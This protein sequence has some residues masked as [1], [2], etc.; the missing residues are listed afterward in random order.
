[1]MND[2]QKKFEDWKVEREVD[3]HNESYQ[4]REGY[5]KAIRDAINL[6]KNLVIPRVINCTVEDLNIGDTVLIEH[7]HRFKDDYWDAWS[8]TNYKYLSCAGGV[9]EFEN[10]NYP[11][12][13]FTLMGDEPM[14]RFVGRYCL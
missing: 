4:Y 7:A 2:I 3:Q 1:M 10:I 13:H 14:H 6:V 8:K 12:E 5:V 9:Y 11:E